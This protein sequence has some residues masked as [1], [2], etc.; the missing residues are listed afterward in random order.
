MESK[1][2]EELQEIWKN[3]DRNE[4]SDEAFEAI[5]LILDERVGESIPHQNQPLK[6]IPESNAGNGGFLSFRTMVSRTL[7]QVIYILGAIG[8]SVYGIILIDKSTE[9]N[10]SG[11]L[12]VT[13]L[14]ILLLGNLAWRITCEAWILLFNIHDVLVSIERKL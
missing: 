14:G 3:N 10:G 13:G 8:L 5:R 7:I 2:T 6:N 9:G 1:S 12:V 11:G 4:Y